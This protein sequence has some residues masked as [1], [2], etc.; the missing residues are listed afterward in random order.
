MATTNAITGVIQDRRGVF[1]LAASVASSMAIVMEIITVA[2]A[3]A[4]VFQS[5]SYVEGFVKILMTSLKV[6]S[7]PSKGVVRKAP[8]RIIAMGAANSMSAERANGH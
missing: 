8:I 4:A 2:T 5:V 1:V 3:I 6:H 7:P